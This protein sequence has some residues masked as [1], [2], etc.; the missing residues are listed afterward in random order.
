MNHETKDDDQLHDQH[1]R[2]GEGAASALPH[3]QK[4][5]QAQVPVPVA[6][7]PAEED[8]S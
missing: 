8:E 5:N 7:P 4:Q 1:G 2:T 3:L 6:P